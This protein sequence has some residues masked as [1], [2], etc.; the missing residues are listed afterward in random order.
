MAAS[1]FSHVSHAVHGS[2]YVVPPIAPPGTF[3]PGTLI[4]VGAHK[5]TIERYLT[6]GGFAH[7]YLVRL[8]RPANGSDIAV[9]KRVAVPDKNALANMRTEVETMKRLRGHR[10]IVTYIDSHASHLKGGGYEVFLL[11]EYCSG[12]GLIDFMN[13]R[14]QNRLKEP[15]VLSII[16]DIAEGVACMH[17]LQPPLLHRDLKVENVLIASSRRFVLCDFGSCSPVREAATSVT[18]CRLLEEDI[19]NHTTLQYRSPEMIDVYRKLPI[20]EKSD[21]WALGVLLYKLCYYTTPFEEQGQLAILNASFKFPSYPVFSDRLK[22]LIASMLRELPS[23]RP[24]IYQVLR[25][26]CAMRGKEVPI[27]DIYSGRTT[28]G[29]PVD[30][31]LASQQITQPPSVIAYQAPQV[32]QPQVLPDIIPMRRGRPT[33]SPHSGISAS[34]QIRA[35]S[36]DPFAALDNSSLIQFPPQD[37]LSARFPSVEQFSLLHDSGA[38]FEFKEF[39][40][41]SPTAFP[42]PTPAK[43]LSTRVM[44]RLADDVFAQPPLTSHKSSTAETKLRES[45]EDRISGTQPT[46]YQPQPQRPSVV[47]TGTMTSPVHSSSPSPDKLNMRVSDALSQPHSRPQSRSLDHQ[48]LA[49][50]LPKQQR[51]VY[52]DTHRTTS[53]ALPRGPSSSRPSL[54]FHR[55]ASS[56]DLLGNGSNS[57]QGNTKIRPNSVYIESNIDFLRDLDSPSREKDIALPIVSGFLTPGRGIEQNLT[58]QSINSQRSDHIESNVEFLR[59]M[60]NESDAAKGGSKADRRL[61]SGSFVGKHVKRASMPSISLANTKTLLAGKFG[62]AFRRF[63]SNSAMHEH[64]RSSS[65]GNDKYLAPISG[66]GPASEVSDEPLESAGI[67]DLSPEAKRELEKRTLIQ[68]EERVAAAAA[69]YKR[70]IANRAPGEGPRQS[71]ASRASTIQNKVKALLNENRAPAPRTAEG[72][73]QHTDELH[74]QSQHSQVDKR[75]AQSSIAKPE[76]IPRT[77]PYSNY[78]REIGKGSTG[79][80]LEELSLPMLKPRATTSSLATDIS[81]AKL[82]SPT[83][84]PTRPPLPPKPQKLRDL[85]PEISGMTIKDKVEERKW[86]KTKPELDGNGELQDIGLVEDPD[87]WQRN[88]AQRYPSLSG[89]EMVET[90]VGN[91]RKP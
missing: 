7:V 10:H 91:G 72:Y 12:G 55:P 49:A 63:E 23:Q 29:K 60:E 32:P 6:E 87:E 77:A 41:D 47:S 88:F 43:D 69:K 37:E 30:R 19:Q 89:L 38:K 62:E 74:Y 40:P 59:A 46:L 36:T 85:V 76:K 21:I 26:I 71:S 50:S 65:P 1:S 79:R 48:P 16:N 22:N 27:K 5:C 11:M 33:K 73:G 4:T 56:A 83:S 81:S 90:V 82:Y 52:L 70:E 58:G 31:P 75:A 15:E 44:E 18:E 8:S 64:H 45:V 80:A 35:V 68:E 86:K 34:P 61:S 78:D 14:L 9:L 20:D 84:S 42:S 54:E 39:N 66:S 17:Y 51:S 13:T 25:E 28:S 3:P 53:Q 67:E 24:N 57:K 2:P